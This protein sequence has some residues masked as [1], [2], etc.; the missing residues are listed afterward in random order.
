[1]TA[2]P[3]EINYEDFCSRRYNEIFSREVYNAKRLTD[4]VERAAQKKAIRDT[5]IECLKIYRDIEPAD[6][7]RVI[8][9]VHV[10]RKSGIMDP[11]VIKAVIS[12][13]NSWKKSSGH[14][15]E[16]MIKLLTNSALA[17][18]GIEIVLQRDLNI[19]IQNNEIANE[20]RDLAWLREQ[21]ASS[22]F[23]LYATVT[24]DE[25]RFVF[26]CIQS[27]TSVRERVTRDREPSMHAMQAFF[28]SIA[29]VLDGSFLAMPK[30]KAM[31]NG[32]T[33][34]S[35]NCGWHAL[36]VFS[37][38]YTDGRIYPIDVDLTLFVD[39]AKQAA[40]YWLTQRQWFN[41]DWIAR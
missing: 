11:D 23:D 9:G 30:F 37:E 19:M 18:H 34:D 40:E 14:A 21:I 26:G 6:I 12:A 8:Y 22:V 2:T 13:D 1:M 27:K 39:H 3:P 5:I 4:E 32:G 28:W 10:D 15:F 33:T 29:I 36:Y 25:C 38:K 7:W 35:P 31:V 20:V 17:P 16:E 41:S 24:R